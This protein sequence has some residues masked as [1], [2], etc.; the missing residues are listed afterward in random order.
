MLKRKVYQELLKW[1]EKV[2]D[3]VHENGAEVLY[4]PWYMILFFMQE[5]EPEKLIYEIDLGG[6]Q[7]ELREI[8]FIRLRLTR[9]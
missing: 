7:R 6:L 5:K 4:L 3:F 1:K 9:L 2:S 8:N